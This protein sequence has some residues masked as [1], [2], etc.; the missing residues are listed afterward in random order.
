M[1]GRFKE[2]ERLAQ[3]GAPSIGQRAEREVAGV[4]FGA[5]S[6]LTRFADGSLGAAVAMPGREAAARYGQA[7]P[8]AYVWLLTEIGDR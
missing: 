3:N 4:V 1:Q 6:F 5:Q 2:T 7:W 8:S